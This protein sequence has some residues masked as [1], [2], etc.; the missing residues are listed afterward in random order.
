[1]IHLIYI[2]NP[3]S[4]LTEHQGGVR[5]KTRQLVLSVTA[6]TVDCGYIWSLQLAVLPTVSQ[7]YWNSVGTWGMG[8]L[9]ALCSSQNAQIAQLSPNK[10]LLSKYL[11]QL[12]LFR[13]WSRNIVQREEQFSEL[14][15]QPDLSRWLL[16]MP[17]HY[18][19]FPLSI[20][21]KEINNCAA[22]PTIGW[23]HHQSVQLHVKSNIPTSCA[24]LLDYQLCQRCNRNFA[25]FHNARTSAYS[26]FTL[27]SINFENLPCL[28]AHL[29]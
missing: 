15:A 7:L 22:Q 28:N 10:T 24:S 6:R 13:A 25:K 20:C 18:Q 5:H 21:N 12:R 9:F 27:V 29:S 16:H 26:V 11:I 1:M 8:K 17:P 3:A 4:N 23:H 14:S 19:L 2:Q